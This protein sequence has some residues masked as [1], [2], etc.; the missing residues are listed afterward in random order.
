VGSLA[1]TAVYLFVVLAL[2]G[3]GAFVFAL[4]VAHFAR[5]RAERLAT[6]RRQRPWG[7]RDYAR[8]RSKYFEKEQR[9]RTF[10][11]HGREP[12]PA[13]PTAA[14]PPPSDLE[15]SHRETLELAPGDLSRETVRAAYVQRMREYHPDRV[16]GLGVKLRALAEEE[17]KRINEAYRFFR[18]RLGF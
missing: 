7:G 18:Q 15:R 8:F 6:E 2:V 3:M 10:R 12:D 5:R 16:A 14:P 4:S 13:P 11:A 17:T 9:A 1:G